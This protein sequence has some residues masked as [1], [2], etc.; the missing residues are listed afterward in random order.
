[1]KHSLLVGLIVG[2]AF[3]LGWLGWFYAAWPPRPWG[4]AA[5][6]ATLAAMS[7]IG[8]IVGVRVR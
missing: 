1:M 2:A 5:V 7:V 6:C 3:P 8:S 4:L